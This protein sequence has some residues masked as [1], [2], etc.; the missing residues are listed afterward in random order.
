MTG[1]KFKVA[2]KRADSD[3]WSVSDNARRKRLLKFLRELI[4]SIES[5]DEETLA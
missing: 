2:H 1:L 5:G 3:K 4:D